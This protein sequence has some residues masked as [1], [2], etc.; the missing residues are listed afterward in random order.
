MEQGW[1]RVHDLSWTPPDYTVDADGRIV[2]HKP[3]EGPHNWGRWGA[4]DQRGTANLLGPEEVV[5]GARLISDG[6]VFSLALPL[7]GGGPVHPERKGGVVHLYAYSGSDFI[8]GSEIGRRFP[9]FQG[10]D[11]YIFMPLQGST[12]WD[13]LAH[14][15]YEDAIYNG[16]WAGTVESAGGAQR[17]SIHHLSNTM[18]GRG[19]LL[20]VARM[21]GVD[22]LAP[23][24]AIGGDELEECARRQGVSVERGDL[25]LVRTG[26]VAWWY[27]LEDKAPFWRDGAPGIGRDSIAWLHERD[28]AALVVDNVGVEVE[29]FEEP[30]RVH[31]PL[32]VSLLRDLGLILGELW[33]LEELSKACAAD[34]EYAFFLCA[35]PLRV[36]NAS[37]SPLNPIA[38]K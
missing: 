11:D 24:H 32:H 36:M 15:A 6:R 3:P 28:I 14:C 21:H 12:Q 38:I 2:G 10:S 20:D 16:F 23:G 18:V 4:L 9:G 30:V 8:A 34:G 17:G 29:P 1:R 26:H 13:A 35:P 27:E 37:G 33:W 25:L 31:Y 7:D 5:R 19:V 22:R